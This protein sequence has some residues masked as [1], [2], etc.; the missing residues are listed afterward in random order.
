M[1][2]QVKLQADV[3]VLATMSLMQL[4]EQWR[5]IV[6]KP[7]PRV[8]VT[9]LRLA[10]GYELQAKARGGLVRATRAQ[11]EQSG[12]KNTRSI[13]LSPGMQLAREWQGKMHI[14]TVDENS[15]IH[16]NGR[17]WLSLSAVARAITGTRWSGPVFFGMVRKQGKAA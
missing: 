11:L 9:L 6:R 3:A 10:L 4:K 16:W 5:A 12:V 8:S 1:S 14:V 2:R 7:V 15:A 17:T 13:T